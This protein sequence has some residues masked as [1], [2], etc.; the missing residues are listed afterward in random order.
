MYTVS[1]YELSEDDKLY[2]YVT[3]RLEYVGVVHQYNI[4]CRSI[5]NDIVSVY[6]ISSEIL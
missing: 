1:D 2:K 5:S 4:G 3:K 6:K